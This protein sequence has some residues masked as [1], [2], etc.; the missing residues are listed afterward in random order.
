[1]YSR[2]YNILP[3]A[4]QEYIFNKLIRSKHWRYG[5][6]SNAQSSDFCLSNP[7]TSVFWF[8]PLMDVPE[9]AEVMFNV[10]KKLIGENYKLQDVYA[11]GQTKGQDGDWHKDHVSHN[12]ENTHTFLYY[13][14]PIWMQE[15]GGYTLFEDEVERPVVYI[16]NSG[17]L[18]KAKSNHLGLG[19]NNIYNGLRTTIAFK[20]RYEEKI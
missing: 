14:N 2:Y 1:M 10:I 8:H 6:V 18:F 20:L 16:P 9:I 11:N 5:G 7:D 19:P 17:I 4:K 13:S 15:W 12:K 3:K